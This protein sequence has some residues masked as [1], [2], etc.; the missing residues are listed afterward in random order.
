[1]AESRTM[2]IVEEL[3]RKCRATSPLTIACGFPKGDKFATIAQK[4][5]GAGAAETASS[6]QIS[7]NGT[8]RSLTKLA[9][10]LEKVVQ[11]AAEQEQRTVPSVN[12]V[13]NIQSGGLPVATYLRRI[14][15]SSAKEG[16]KRLASWK[17]QQ[18]RSCS[19]YLVQKVGLLIKEI[20]AFTGWSGTRR[21]DHHES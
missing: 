3:R 18:E 10:K 5:N 6:G 4:G 9:E 2:R 11:G 17:F 7:R 1:M 14:R 13:A 16:E 20:E 21:V 19:L 8:I 12:L 15:G